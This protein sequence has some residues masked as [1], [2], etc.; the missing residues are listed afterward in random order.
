VHQRSMATAVAS[1]YKRD[2]CYELLYVK[3]FL[4]LR[5]IVLQGRLVRAIDGWQL[6]HVVQWLDGD[7]S[8]SREESPRQTMR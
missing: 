4:L 8:S 3:E 2:N 7:E 6:D 5:P 1:A